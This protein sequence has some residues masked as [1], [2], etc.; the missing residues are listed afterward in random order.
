MT[1]T[2]VDSVYDERERNRETERERE[3]EVDRK[4]SGRAFVIWT[5]L[6]GDIRY[7][8]LRRI[9][10]PRTRPIADTFRHVLVPSRHSQRNDMARRENVFAGCNGPSCK[11]IA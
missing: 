5:Q 3:G 6:T 4:Q 2:A 8:T 9:T 10:S 11:I 1:A 7:V